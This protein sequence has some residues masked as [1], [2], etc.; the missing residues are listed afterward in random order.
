VIGQSAIGPSAIGNRAIGNVHDLQICDVDVV[1]WSIDVDV[2]PA[3][4]V[5]LITLPSASKVCRVANPRPRQ[6]NPAPGPV[7]VIARALNDADADVGWANVC[8]EVQ[9]VA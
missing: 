3:M 7:G 1:V 9:A 2:P 6:I 4:A 8:V 5:S